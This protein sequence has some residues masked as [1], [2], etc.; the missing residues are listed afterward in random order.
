[1][2]KIRKYQYAGTLPLGALNELIMS[3][4][5]QTPISNKVQANDWM[6]N[7]NPA[8]IES[9]LPQG[10]SIENTPVS[11]K[12]T[13]I[14]TQTP[15]PKRNFLQSKTG[16]AVAS[17]GISAVSS[18]LSNRLTGNLF[19]NDE[20]GQ[21]LGNIFS[22]GIGS[23]ADTMANNILR[24]TSLTQGLAKNV[25]SSLAGAGAGIAANYI[26]QGLNN[27]GGDTMLSRGLSQGLATGLGTLGGQTLSNMIQGN[28]A[29]N[30]LSS[31]IKALKGAGGAASGLSKAAAIGNIA[32]LGGSVVGAG[33]SAAFGPSKEYGGKYGSITQGLDTAYDLASAGVNFIPGIGQGISGAMALN[34]GLSNIFGSTD[35]MTKTDAILGSAF[36]PFVVKWA[37]MFGSSKTGTFNNQ[38]W[39]NTEKTNS[40]MG[41]AFGDLGE[42]FDRARREAGKTYGTFSQ[43]AKRDAQ[44]NID[45]ANYAWKKVLNMADQNILQNIKSQDMSSINNQRYAQN[46]QGGFKQTAIGKQGMKIF[47]NATNHNIGMR[48]L[49]GAALIDNKQMILCSA[50]D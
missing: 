19:G 2:H 27:L 6:V 48:L 38:S 36:M 17:A 23:T 11:A 42:K 50:Q 34:K 45:F 41:D 37:N 22:Q 35:G 20:T 24:G 31:S 28:G 30:T 25:G 12:T 46:I 7:W 49:S 3:Q 9:S 39:Q 40:F 18:A 14:S 13:P 16:Q 15:K 4:N 26:G 43:G 10:R 29:V 8:T 33:L 1:M 32:G 5:L 44:K 47:N 21:V